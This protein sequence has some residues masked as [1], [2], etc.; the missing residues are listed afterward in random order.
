M[1]A[2]EIQSHAEKL[3]AAF[4]DKAVAEAARKARAAEE[5]RD[6][7]EARTWRRVEAALVEMRGPR[8]S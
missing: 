5:R 8:V 7:E 3:R 1:H 2:V 4:G 6:E